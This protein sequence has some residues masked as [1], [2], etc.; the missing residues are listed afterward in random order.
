MENR[1]YDSIH[2]MAKDI[3][4]KN[5]LG[6]EKAQLPTSITINLSSSDLESKPVLTSFEVITNDDEEEDYD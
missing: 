2:R 4:L 1:D 3:G 5:V 6:D